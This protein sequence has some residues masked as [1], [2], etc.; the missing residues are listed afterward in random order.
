ML[1]QKSATL[2]LKMT[3]LLASPISLARRVPL[4]E[5]HSVQLI[6]DQ[7]LGHFATRLETSTRA[8]FEV[9][10]IAQVIIYKLV[11]I[12]KE[13]SSAFTGEVVYE[14]LSTD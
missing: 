14:N 6:V 7:L 11:K 1:V 4:T 9:V 3:R 5:I 10:L 13:W 8:L 2:A 12:I